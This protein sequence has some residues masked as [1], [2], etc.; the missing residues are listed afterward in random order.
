MSIADETIILYAV[1]KNYLE[2]VAVDK[3]LAFEKEFL[4]Y[5]N[6]FYKNIVD[7]INN[8]KDISDELEKKI[9]EAITSFK[10]NSQK[11]F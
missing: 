1:T 5:I 9:K 11:F 2:D 3:I 8:K 4:D 6:K 7:E 10:N